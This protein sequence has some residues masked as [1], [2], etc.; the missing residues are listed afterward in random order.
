[1]RDYASCVYTIYGSGET[2]TPAFAA[3]IAIVL[4]AG[5]VSGAIWGWREG[6]FGFAVMGAFLGLVVGAGTLA[7]IALFVY[8]LSVAVS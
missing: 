8:L 5:V 7:V 4:L 6:G 2:L 1:M 3:V